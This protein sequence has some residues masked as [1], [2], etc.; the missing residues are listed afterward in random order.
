MGID[1]G[2]KLTGTTVLAV[3]KEGEVLF[4][5]VDKGVD[6]DDF[7]FN[8]AE[9]FKPRVIFIDAPLSLPG[10]YQGLDDC[11]NY[12]F[13]H[14]DLELKAMSPMFLGGMAARAIELK[15]RLE[16]ELGIE[17]RETYP[18]VRAN[19]ME[20]KSR[21]YKGSQLGLKDCRKTVLQN[22]PT[23]LS[24][25]PLAIKTWHHLDALLALQSAQEYC[26]GNVSS[27]G[28]QEEGMI[29]V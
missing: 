24:V 16:N 26:Q 12:H 7:I 21:G 10:I 14:A 3:Q 11:K 28:K 1:Y 29:Y 20:L 8:A 9:H 25:K 4:F 17:V 2:S 22:M 23:D 19:Q 15:T 5:A 27:Y 18:R 6:A 13:R